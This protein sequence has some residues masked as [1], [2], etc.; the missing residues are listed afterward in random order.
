MGTIDMYL[1]NIS[2]GD[3]IASLKH[4]A[5][6]VALKSPQN[7]NLAAFE[8]RIGAKQ[9]IYK[10][11]QISKRKGTFWVFTL[12]EFESETCS[13]LLSIQ[14]IDGGILH[15][16]SPA[17]PR[18]ILSSI[19]LNSLTS[20]QA[21]SHQEAEF[22][23]RQIQ[24]YSPSGINVLVELSAQLGVQSMSF[25]ANHLSHSHMMCSSMV[26]QLCS[27]LT[28]FIDH[29]HEAAP[30]AHYVLAEKHSLFRT[31][32]SE[33]RRLVAGSKLVVVYEDVYA[34]L[35]SLE[36]IQG[37]KA[38]T[39]GGLSLESAVQRMCEDSC[40][41]TC[42]CL[43]VL[44]VPQWL[45]KRIVSAC[46]CFQLKV[47]TFEQKEQYISSCSFTLRASSFC[48][49]HISSL[50][51]LT[52]TYPSHNTHVQLTTIWSPKPPTLLHRQLDSIFSTV[53]NDREPALTA[54]YH[55]LLQLPSKKDEDIFAAA[56]IAYLNCFH[57]QLSDPWDRVSAQKVDRSI[58]RVYVNKMKYVDAV[59]PLGFR[60]SQIVCVGGVDAHL[61]HELVKM[62]SLSQPKQALVLGEGDRRAQEQRSDYVFSSY[63]PKKEENWAKYQET[64]TAWVKE[65]LDAVDE[66][67]MV[68]VCCAHDIPFFGTI[69]SQLIHHMSSDAV[70]ILN[71]HSVNTPQERVLLEMV[72]DFHR[73]VTCTKVLPLLDRRANQL[74]FHD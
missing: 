55:S 50:I 17:L 49:P 72:H 3:V 61:A 51:A 67:D 18:S 37:K 28:G 23:S 40:W 60:P 57:R 42:E 8:R 33:V 10:E 63:P 4:K 19:Q 25:M 45:E 34:E 70:V 46:A 59:V 39:I 31:I 58:V 65:Q 12:Y 54:L 24:S 11:F 35:D 52:P 73:Q 20:L 6:Y 36:A 21:P 43:L 22:I 5:R 41:Q 15:M 64:I 26:P 56:H 53:L 30:Q 7:F 29:L 66:V 27:N 13:P 62:Y 48:L 2:I 14:S 1:S 68:V 9:I 16:L 47:D 71:D 74:G 44:R 69:L 32:P 38:V